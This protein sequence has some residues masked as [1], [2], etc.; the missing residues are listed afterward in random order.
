M[1]NWKLSK[2][3]HIIVI[4]S[5]FVFQVG[6]LLFFK[7]SKRN[8]VKIKHFYPCSI[9]LTVLERKRK[10]K[11][12]Y[13]GIQIVHYFF[14]PITNSE[15]TVARGQK[16]SLQKKGSN[17]NYKIMYYA[18]CEIAKKMHVHAD[19]AK[20]SLRHGCCPYL[21]PKKCRILTTCWTCMLCM[22]AVVIKLS[23]Y[24]CEQDMQNELGQSPKIRVHDEG[25]YTTQSDSKKTSTRHESVRSAAKT[26]LRY[27]AKRNITFITAK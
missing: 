10:Q 9:L 20:V 23:A 18:Q 24:I 25:S 12:H 8:F 26:L 1:F 27:K 19:R 4:S 7:C 11:R 16:I 13:L 14:H 17:S 6:T 2:N 3:V 5:V 21:Q 15:A 22:C